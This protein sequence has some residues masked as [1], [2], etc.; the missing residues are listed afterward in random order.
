[1]LIKKPVNNRIDLMRISLFLFHSNLLARTGHAERYTSIIPPQHAQALAA[2]SSSPCSRQHSQYSLSGSSSYSSQWHVPPH[3]A[4]KG[5]SRITSSSRGRS[6]TAGFFSS[7]M[8]RAS[9]GFRCR[10]RFA[11]STTMRMRSIR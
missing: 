10:G 2:S 11:P 6:V 4:Q 5:G 3:H 9:H 7:V 8:A 1:M